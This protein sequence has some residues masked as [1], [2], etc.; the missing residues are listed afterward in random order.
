MIRAEAT[1]TETDS[2]ISDTELLIQA[3]DGADKLLQ[4]DE[5]QLWIDFLERFT[6]MNE[7]A[8]PGDAERS[9][10]ATVQDELRKYVSKMLRV[11]LPHP[12]GTQSTSVGEV[13]FYSYP[14]HGF[15]DFDINT[16]M[17]YYS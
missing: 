4:V 2:I 8:N 7:L 16:Q 3:A 9:F 11:E 10:E 15:P 13:D 12:A 14:Q 17:D 5:S 6:W 1:A